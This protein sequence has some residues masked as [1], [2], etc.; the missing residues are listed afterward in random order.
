MKDCPH[1]A[2]GTEPVLEIYRGKARTAALYFIPNP[3]VCY[4]ASPNLAQWE[5]LYWKYTE[6]RLAHCSG[7]RERVGERERE[8]EENKIWKSG[9]R[10]WDRDNTG[11]GEMGIE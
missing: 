7:D 5:S 4:R 3:S 11:A 10:V 1:L 8:R 2:Q 9:Y 6:E